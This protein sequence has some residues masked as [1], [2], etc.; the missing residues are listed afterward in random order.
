MN[1]DSFLT[2]LATSLYFIPRY[3]RSEKHSRESDE[4]QKKLLYK[5]LQKARIT[6]WGKRYKFEDIVSSSDFYRE[7]AGIV[8]VCEYS[9]LKKY[10]DRMYA[11]EKDVLWPGKCNLMAMTSSTTSSSSKAI[12]V[13]NGNLKDTHLRGGVDST[14]SYLKHNRGSRLFSGKTL[15]VTASYHPEYNIGNTKAASISAILFKKSPKLISPFKAPTSDIALMKDFKEKVE[16]MAAQ[17]S[18]MHITA[19]AGQPPWVLEILK[20]VL[21]ITGKD[22]ISQVWPDLEVFFHGGMSFTP[23]RPSFERLI[24][25]KRMKYVETYNAS[26][27]FFGVQTDPDDRSMSLCVDYG[28]FYEFIPHSEYIKGLLKA[29]PVWEVK[30]GVNYVMLITTT[31]GLWRYV[32]GDVVSFTSLRP[33]KFIIT[34][35]TSQSL[36]I[37]GEDLN[38]LVVTEAIADACRET[39]AS[40][41]EFTVGCEILPEDRLRHNF[42]IE[43]ETQADDIGHFSERLD[44]FL[45]KNSFSY[46]LVREINIVTAPSVITA[47][48][49]SFLAYMASIGHLDAQRKVPRFSETMD[50]I[51]KI[52]SQKPTL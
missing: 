36:N 3:I 27:G 11:G 33:Y 43:F 44:H 18:G 19:L 35:R 48:E 23:Y 52:V 31:G 42:L 49:G 16:A 7:F 10:I 1:A 24:P 34:G 45:T 15:I 29:V 4:I 26:E 22:N 28:V 9:D 38:V 39:G 47:A 51:N 32:L 20:K 5:M 8:P 14:A 30:T 41:R 25:S 13:L 2:S 21:Q 50:I 17:V 46:K 37:K 40:V 12:P 6:A